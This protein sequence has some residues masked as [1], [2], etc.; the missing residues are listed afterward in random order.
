VRRHSRYT[1]RSGVGSSRVAKLP[2]SHLCRCHRGRLLGRGGW[3]GDGDIGVC[4]GEADAGLG[5]A[6]IL[7]V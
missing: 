1:L 6:I 2:C 7:M 5:A 3:G 4:L